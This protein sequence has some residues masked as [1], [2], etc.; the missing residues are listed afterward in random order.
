[1]R[2]HEGVRSE[3]Y[4]PLPPG[5]RFH[6]N[7]SVEAPFEAGEYVLRLTLVQEHV[8]WLDSLGVYADTPCEVVGHAA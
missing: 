3:I 5:R 6:Y 7:M 8:A 2:W 4:P 1:M